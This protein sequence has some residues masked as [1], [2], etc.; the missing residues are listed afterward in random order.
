MYTHNVDKRC[1]ATIS[2]PSSQMV[3]MVQ[4]AP[5]LVA[6]QINPEYLNHR[7]RGSSQ[8]N[9]HPTGLQIP[10]CNRLR[11]RCGFTRTS[12]KQAVSCVDSSI[13]RIAYAFAADKCANSLARG[14]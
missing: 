14:F 11:T 2:R 8:P 3:W 7:P 1:V 4:G 9:S 13:P 10:H 6:T 5:C 12:M